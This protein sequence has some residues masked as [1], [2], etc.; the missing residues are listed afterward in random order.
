MKNKKI[1]IPFILEQILYDLKKIGARPI[2]V[3]GCIRDYFLNIPCKDYD[4]EIFNIYKLE[5]ISSI[6]SKY[7]SVKFIGKS[8][9]VL[10]LSIN[11]ID[12]DFAL[13][14]SEIKT[15]LKHQNFK[16]KTNAKLSYKEA[17]L[18]RDFTINSI[19][20][21]FFKNDFLDPFNGI[22]DLNIKKLKH[23][24]TKTF[25][26]DSLR[27]YR[28]ISFSSRFELTL[29]K[30]TFDLCQQ[31]VLNNDL[32]YLPKERIYEEFKKIF[33]KSNKP[34]LAFILLENLGI[35]KYFCEFK[36][37]NLQTL[38]SMDNL[39]QIIRK[40]NIKDEYRVLYLFY[41]ILCQNL[42]KKNIKTFLYK[43]TNE[44]K[45]IQ[46]IS[47]LLIYQNYFNEITLKSNLTIRLKKL[48][49][50]VDI[51]DLAILYLSKNVNKKASKDIF[52]YILE[53]SA[54]LNIKNKAIKPLIYGKDLIF[55]GLKPNKRFKNILEY[56]LEL[57]INKNLEKEE[58]IKLLKVTLL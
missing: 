35:L 6:L 34:S 3:G 7:A 55:L 28:A 5:E 57:Q 26:E 33:L 46:I 15:G 8:F 32:D 38:T 4:I 41:C 1:C 21:D 47:N 51:E 31:M 40:L 48:S 37:I 29:D 53:I 44:K 22:K 45:I 27:V 52:E 24:N 2:L 9:G 43:L 30:H 16:V 56:A 54:K 18:R 50:H 12:F 42:S 17:S 58:I 19:G 39:V 23:I 49:L 25:I 11:K 10:S 14:R 36:D 20:Y 13:A